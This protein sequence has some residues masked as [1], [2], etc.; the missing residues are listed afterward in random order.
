MYQPGKITTIKKK[1]FSFPLSELMEQSIDNFVQ[2]HNRGDICEDC[3][4][5]ELQSDINASINV[6]ITEEQANELRD[7]YL[8]GGMYADI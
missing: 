5:A 4:L 8:R 7:Y 2:A 1:Q 6:E 3:Y